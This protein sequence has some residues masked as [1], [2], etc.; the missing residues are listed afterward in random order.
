M[1][2]GLIGRP[3]FGGLASGLDTNA[4]LSGLLE[5]ERIPLNRIQSR[6]AELAN[7][8][9]LMRE[10]NSRLVRLREASQALDNRNDS[11][12]AASLT[13]EFL[14]YT[15]SSTNEDI[16]TVS[17]GAGAAPGDIEIE[18]LQLARGARRFSTTYSDVDQTIAL[19]PGESLFVQLADEDLDADPP[20]P[21]TRIG[22]GVD[23]DAAAGLT[24][25]D[26]RDQI[27]TNEGNGGKVRADIIQFAE[28]EFQLVL[29]T[30]G[31]GSSNAITV[32]GD[33][34]FEPEVEGRDDPQ[35][36]Q[37]RLFG[38]G[39][40]DG[41][42]IIERESNTIDDA[43]TGVTFDLKRIP[44]DEDPVSE[45]L[46]IDV[47]NDEIAAG[48]DT[49]VQAYNDV[50]SFIDGQFRFNESTNTAG[51]LAG[52]FTLRQVQSQLRDMVSR[53]FGFSTNQS[54]PFAP[55]T[56]G[57]LGGAITN[58]GI[59]IESGG[60]LRVDR[61]KLDEALALDP[62]S[63]REFLSGR[64]RAEPD[65]DSPSGDGIEPDLFDEGFATLFSTQL[66]QL[67]RSGDGTLAERDESYDRRLRDFDDSIERFEARLAQREE[68]LVLRFS[69]L[70]RVV[71]G[72]Q[73]QQGFLSSIPGV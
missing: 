49:F 37:I 69:E 48:L 60:T 64:A 21:P 32:L 28:N 42:G 55:L 10:L 23:A 50:L 16:V 53:A 18:V 45:T 39:R 11:G 3:T 30:S 15:G 43:L 13:E 73:N 44:S 20:E 54:N 46:T 6:R 19:A 57:G 67:V 59:T 61:E 34:E 62:I 12:S 56:D 58:I 35:N 71:A 5:I 70:E 7:E 47:D 52:D 66:E 31:T 1:T 4:L 51:P 26:I 9:S 29:T 41:T 33:F 38:I 63:V 65:P 24:L 68:R 72:L 40:E 27:N 36:A 8:R 25:Q 22:V 2:T 17:A 14:Q